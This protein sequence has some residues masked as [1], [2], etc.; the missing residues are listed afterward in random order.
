MVNERNFH[1]L[2]EKANSLQEVSILFCGSLFRDSALYKHRGFQEEHEWRLIS[3]CASHFAGSKHIKAEQSNIQFACINE[4]IKSHISLDFRKN[5]NAGLIHCI[6]LGPKFIG[7]EYDFEFFVNQNITNEIII[8]QS[9]IP[10]R[11]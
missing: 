3:H 9:Q 4:N 10:Y 11:G 5:W 7:N 2:K 8:Q 6:V 1:F